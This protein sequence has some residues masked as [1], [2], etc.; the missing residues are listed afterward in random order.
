MLDQQVLLDRK[1]KWARR[2]LMEKP[3]KL[4][5]PVYRELL[6]VEDKLVRLETRVIPVILALQE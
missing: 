5:Q 2:D 4:D 1:E 3:A 6:A